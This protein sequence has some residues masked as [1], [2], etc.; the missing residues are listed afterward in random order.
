MLFT[1]NI[2]FSIIRPSKRD[3]Q[4]RCSLKTWSRAGYKLSA[5]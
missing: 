5:V 4:S 3:T 1:I 2:S